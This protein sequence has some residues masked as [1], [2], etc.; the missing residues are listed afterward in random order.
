VRFLKGAL[1]TLQVK[2]LYDSSNL[3]QDLAAGVTVGMMLVPQAMAYAL[4]AGL[5]P[6]MGLYASILP[7]LIYAALGTSRH[8]AVGPV[9]V[10]SLLVLSQASQFA[11]R[12]SPE[13]IGIVVLL[14]LLAGM[15]QCVCGILRL[16]IM[17]NFMSYAV[18]SGFISA[19]AIIICLS[20]LGSIFGAKAGGQSHSTGAGIM[21]EIPRLA[22]EANFP[23]VI[24]G[25][26]GI[27][28]LL[29]LKKCC[30]R[31]P[32]AMLLTVVTAVL[33][34][35]LKLQHAGVAVIGEIPRGL[36]TF[37][38]PTLKPQL[39]WEL[40]PTALTILFVSYLESIG[41][42][43]LIAARERYKIDPNREFLALGLA[44]IGAALSSG[45]P[46]SGSFSRTAVNYEAGARTK[47]A[48]V[49]CALL[50]LGA[51]YALTP[52]FYF[53]PKAMLAAIVIAAAIGLINVKEGR[54]FFKIK[55]SDGWSL[56]LTFIATLLWG[57]Q[58]G[59][60]SGIT[61]S[62]WLLI[63][64]NAH[65]E[66]PELGC[67]YEEGTF[68][69]LRYFPNARIIPEVLILRI[70][71]SMN[72]ANIELIQD[73]L[74]EVLTNRHEIKWVVLE[75][76][77]VNDIDGIAI[78][79]LGV[80]IETYHASG[81]SFALTGAKGSIRNLL[82]RAGWEQRYPHLVREKTLS[83][84]LSEIGKLQGTFPLI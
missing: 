29:L 77:G 57:A 4:L 49:F 43:R 71:A 13:Y 19:S 51:M 8:L 26:A 74:T 75:L 11:L 50:V 37:S 62:L 36:P 7:L 69:D 28:L 25:V 44:N 79:G 10:V 18:T 81:I 76:A 68:R 32:A 15:A 56:L 63:W 60:I 23:T 46:I 72:F 22:Q 78:E 65:P 66:T 6:V 61:F 33:V 39:I 67:I 20:Q 59:I 55:A 16:G 80:L 31:Y 42:A 82:A 21:L 9:A 83:Q 45:C 38:F 12:G 5:P 24:I 73:R 14:A 34:Y 3:R 52:L 30:P 35:V 70:D 1:H 58:I 48:S 2:G 27:V 41:I 47:L 64:R 53:L 17:T 54:Q 84:F 40:L